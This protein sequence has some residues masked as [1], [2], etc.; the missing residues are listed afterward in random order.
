[1][2]RIAL[3]GFQHETN[4]IGVGR[5]GLAE[6]EMADSW[7][8]LLTG[9][10]VLSGT[11]GMN[12][13]IAGFAAAAQAAGAALHPILWC[14]AEPSGPVTDEA[15][16]TI[17]ARILDGIADA[18]PFDG[19][20]L[21][22]H[23]AMITDS[24]ADGEGALLER[25]RARTGPALP[26]A[27]CLDMHANISA[28]LVALA[29][30]ICIYKTYPHLDMAETGARAW[31][32]LS[33]MLAGPRPAKAFLQAPFLVP[34]PAQHTG[35]EPMRGLYAA[36]PDSAEAHVEMAVG[37]TAGDTP[38]IGPSVI[39]YA[40]TQMQADKLAC[41]A[42]RR[43]TA[44]QPHLETRLATPPE[45]LADAQAAPPGRP[46]ILADVQDNPG[47]GASSDTTGLLRALIEARVQN[48]LLGLMHDPDLA[49]KAHAAGRGAV[50][51]GALG[52][53]S[54]LAGDRPFTGRFR[55][56][57]LSDGQLRYTGAMY[58]GGTATLGPSCALHL[59][60]THA[61][62]TVVVTS[63]RT[64]CL[65]LAQFTHFGL[66]PSGA[67]LIVV[68][69]TAHFRADFEPIAA[70]IIPVASPGLFPCD[71]ADIALRGACRIAASRAQRIM[72]TSV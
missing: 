50:I 16:D 38:D 37:F 72:D 64:Q 10:E 41:A 12:L 52:G 54:G 35:A 34:L 5:A 71:L 56:D 19:L 53:R 43:L 42:M 60:D 59:E 33:A 18:A 46:V 11:Q 57:A 48:A 65:D 30:A 66:S 63:I 58:S 55:V 6:F 9:A 4:S 68:K 39:A 13:P 28:R 1:M 40:P 31:H 29:D 69:S 2:P 62:V 20:F 44:A 22:L 15:F 17:A 8:R 26:I 32:R 45:A 23:G 47:A 70:R 14:A 25:I 24:G 61:D 3:A 51:D 67:R 27:L 21:D 36:L 7:P 49:A